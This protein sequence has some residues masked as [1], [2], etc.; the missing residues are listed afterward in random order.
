M[1]KESR[2]IN[3]L[4][5]VTNLIGSNEA[6][7]KLVIVFSLYINTKY[8]SASL[9]KCIYIPNTPTSVDQNWINTFS[10]LGKNLRVKKELYVV[11]CGQVVHVEME[12]GGEGTRGIKVML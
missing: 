10:S 1:T 5:I 9:Y 6:S 12:S 7:E 4:K 2:L 8:Y 11:L 3:T